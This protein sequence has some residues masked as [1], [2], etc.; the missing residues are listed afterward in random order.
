[1]AQ[2]RAGWGNLGRLISAGLHRK[3]QNRG[4]Q[5]AQPKISEDLSGDDDATSSRRRICGTEG[6]RRMPAILCSISGL[7]VDSIIRSRTW[8]API[9]RRFDSSF[10]IRARERRPSEGLAARSIALAQ[11][12]IPSASSSAGMARGLGVSRSRANSIATPLPA[13]FDLVIAP[14]ISRS[15]LIESRQ[16]CR[17]G[18][19]ATSTSIRRSEDWDEIDDRS[20]R[21]AR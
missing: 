21:R 16:Q 15:I 5:N 3:P 4:S 11:G 14:E 8:S 10:N 1:M 9:A 18:A 7:R 17:G 19:S 6:V 13:S 2:N 12:R 20:C